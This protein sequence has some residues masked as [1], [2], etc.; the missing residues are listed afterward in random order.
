MERVTVSNLSSPRH[1]AHCFI[2]VPNRSF[3]QIVERMKKLVKEAGSGMNK[4]PV[5]VHLEHYI[6]VSVGS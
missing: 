6:A 1:K 2:S 3:F 4:L 5:S